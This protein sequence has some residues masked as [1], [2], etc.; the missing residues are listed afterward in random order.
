MLRFQGLCHLGGCGTSIWC[1][2]RATDDLA[3]LL[4]R[5]EKRQA[6]EQN[7][8]RVPDLEPHARLEPRDDLVIKAGGIEGQGQLFREVTHLQLHFG[9]DFLGEERGLMKTQ[10]RLGRAQPWEDPPLPQ[11]HSDAP[12]HMGKEPS[13]PRLSQDSAMSFSTGKSLQDREGQA[14]NSDLP[15]LE[16]LHT[17]VEA[18]MLTAGP[19]RMLGVGGADKSVWVVGSGKQWLFC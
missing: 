18:Q 6:H 10:Q 2:C 16:C 17:W 14:L 13:A 19:R 9:A 7:P 3:V 4:Q 11:H 15:T 1:W 8:H 12:S 5:G